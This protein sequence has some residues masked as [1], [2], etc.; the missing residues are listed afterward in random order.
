[1]SAD[2]WGVTRLPAWL[3]RASGPGVGGC[4]GLQTQ[5]GTS[6]PL[7]LGAPCPPLPPLPVLPG[8]GETLP[9]LVLPETQMRPGQRSSAL[10]SAS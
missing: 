6:T 8:M 4:A 1:M 3:F 7:R 5:A 9:S 2:F 10:D